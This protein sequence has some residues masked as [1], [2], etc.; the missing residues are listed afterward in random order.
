MS[1]GSNNDEPVVQLEGRI[2]TPPGRRLPGL[3]RKAS[4]ALIGGAVVAGFAFGID[5]PDVDFDLPLP[6]RSGITHS[7]LPILLAC[8]LLRKQMRKLPVLGYLMAGYA[9]SIGVHL[10]A[11]LF[12]AAWTGGALIYLPLVGSIGGLSL[13]FLLINAILA[14]GIAVYSCSRRG[15]PISVITTLGFS[16]FLFNE[17]SLGLELLWLSGGAAVLYAH[18]RGI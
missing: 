11:D 17:S 2:V 9:G 1:D 12:P 13:P 14:L 4:L 7:I 3:G 10:L 8:L 6:H 15:V 18:K 16:Y 5:F